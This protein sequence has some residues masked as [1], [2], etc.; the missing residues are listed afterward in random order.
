MK[1]SLAL[2][3]SLF[4]ACG[5]E[6]PGELKF[7]AMSLNIATGAGP[8]W[9][10]GQVRHRQRQFL[11]ENRADFVGLQ[12]VG[13]FIPQT[14]PIDSAAVVL[15]EGGRLVHGVAKPDGDGTYGNALWVANRFAVVKEETILFDDKGDEQTRALLVVTVEDGAHRLR[16]GVTHLSVYGPRPA[17]LRSEQLAGIAAQDLDVLIGDMNAYPAEVDPQLPGLKLATGECI[18]Q[19]RARPEF[20]STGSLILTEGASDHQYA[21]YAEFTR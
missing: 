20:T 7:T 13:V 18:D 5:P 14:G 15:P 21:P 4:S 17:G 11:A 2:L 12:E 19:V 16:V 6:A 10:T 8:A 3:L 1:T 9:N